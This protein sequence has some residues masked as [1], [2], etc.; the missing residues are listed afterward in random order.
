M[1]KWLLLYHSGARGD[2]INSI[3]FGDILLQS[4]QNP[5]IVVTGTDQTL[6]MHGYNEVYSPHYK[7]TKFEDFN[8]L[9]IKA[10]DEFDIM[11]I[12]KLATHKLMKESDIKYDNVLSVRNFENTFSK[13]DS[14]FQ[15][16]V[17]FK[18]L[19]DIEYI[20]T[21]FHQIRNRYLTSEEQNRIIH[22]IKINLDIFD[23]YKIEFKL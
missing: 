17:Q 15:L 21:L 22:N 7:F 4:Y 23:L 8:V 9:R 6:R 11:C 12:A 18:K 5:W 2:F 16:I 1:K 19:F 10:Q 13:L 14:Q 20:N 3:L